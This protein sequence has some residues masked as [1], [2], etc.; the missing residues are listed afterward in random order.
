MN[1]FELCAELEVRLERTGRHP[2]YKELKN[3][4]NYPSNR[5]NSSAVWGRPK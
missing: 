1:I 5:S 2:V 4:I 3:K